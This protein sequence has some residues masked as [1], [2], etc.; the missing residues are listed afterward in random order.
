[1]ANGADIDDACRQLDRQSTWSRWLPQYRGVKANDANR[2]KE[3][4]IENAQ[5]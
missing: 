4:V 1:M 2:L 3:M 5:L